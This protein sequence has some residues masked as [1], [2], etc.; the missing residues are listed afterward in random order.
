MD[1]IEKI[2]SDFEDVINSVYV[3][4]YE[5]ENESYKDD[6]FFQPMKVPGEKLLDKPS[7]ETP[8]IDIDQ[9]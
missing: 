3:G 6:P 5:D 2:E 4:V 1:L 8:D 7:E 9:L